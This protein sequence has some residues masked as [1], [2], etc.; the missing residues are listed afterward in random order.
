MGRPRPPVPPLEPPLG[1][2]ARWD[3]CEKFIWRKGGKRK[4]RRRA[5]KVKLFQDINFS[6]Q[7]FKII[8]ITISSVT[9]ST[10]SQSKRHWSNITF[11]TRIC[12]RKFLVYW[13][14][15]IVECFV[16]LFQ[17]RIEYL[18]LNY[19]WL[20]EENPQNRIKAQIKM[21]MSVFLYLY[22]YCFLL[23]SLCLKVEN[24]FG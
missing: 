11:N 17:T 14:V 15:L 5:L 6:K 22:L 19:K 16:F 24:F 3:N 21:I 8:I 18:R 7:C 2:K 1:I 4:K 23:H 9:Q 12:T 13:L 20:A 10:A